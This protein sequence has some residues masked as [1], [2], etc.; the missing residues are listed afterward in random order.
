MFINKIVIWYILLQ[1]DFFLQYYVCKIYLYCY[2]KLWFMYFYCWIIFHCINVPQV[3]HLGSCWWN[4]VI[5]KC[6][7]LHSLTN[8]CFCLLNHMCNSLSRYIPRYI[9]GMKLLGHRIYALS[10]AVNVFSK[11]LCQFILPLAAN[12]SSF[13][14][15][16]F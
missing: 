9:L 13:S 16:L 6:L 14:L 3:I 5:A 12:D 1:L 2:V 4:Y 8:I 15:H 7:L 10:N 11:W